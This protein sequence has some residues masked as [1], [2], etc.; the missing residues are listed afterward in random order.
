MIFT[1][2]IP[3]LPKYK[4]EWFN[5]SA[6]HA[7]STEGLKL[8]VRWIIFLSPRRARSLFALKTSRC[9]KAPCIP[10]KPDDLLTIKSSVVASRPGSF[11]KQIGR[12]K[13]DISL[14]V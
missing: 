11:N 7:P 9:L 14:F 1:G 13:L 12:G 3:T 4:P 2:F 6:S 5:R 10:K 8:H